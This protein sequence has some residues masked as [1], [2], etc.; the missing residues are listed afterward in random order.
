[1]N[2][3]LYLG[4]QRVVPSTINELYT[5][6]DN[7]TIGANNAI[8]VY[9]DNVTGNIGW[10]FRD[11]EKNEGYTIVNPRVGD[12]FYYNINDLTLY[13]TIVEVYNDESILVDNGENNTVRYFKQNKEITFKEIPN[14]Y[15]KRLVSAKAV[16]EAIENNS[17]IEYVA[18]DNITIGN[19]TINAYGE[20]LSLTGRT[21][22]T[23]TGA[24]A[25]TF[26]NPQVGDKAYHNTY[27][28]NLYSPIL[29]INGDTSITLSGTIYSKGVMGITHSGEVVT[30][31]DVDKTNIY[32][33]LSNIEDTWIKCIFTEDL[34]EFAVLGKNHVA[35][36]TNGIDWNTIILPE[37][38]SSW[39]DIAHV[40]TPNGY[41]IGII[42]SSSIKIYEN[43]EWINYPI[44]LPNGIGTLLKIY[45]LYGQVI[46]GDSSNLYVYNVENKLWTTVELPT[47]GSYTIYDDLTLSYTNNSNIYIMGESWITVS[48]PATS[49]I[50]GIISNSNGAVLVAQTDKCFVS[51]DGSNWTTYNLPYSDTWVSCLEV[52]GIVYLVGDTYTLYSNDFGETWTQIENVA[53]ICAVSGHIDHSVETIYLNQ[54]QPVQFNS[55]PSEYSE[56]LMSAKSVLENIKNNSGSTYS[57]GNNITIENNTISAV[58]E[59]TDKPYATKWIDEEGNIRYS[60][61]TVNIND[62]LYTDLNGTENGTITNIISSTEIEAVGTFNSNELYTTTSTGV[63]KSA[64]GLT[65]SDHYINSKTEYFTPSSTTITNARDGML[66]LTPRYFASTGRYVIGGD[67][68]TS[69]TDGINWNYQQFANEIYDIAY[70][71]GKYF[72]IDYRSWDNTSEVQ[73]YENIDSNRF[74]PILREESSNW[75]SI[76]I[77]NNIGVIVAHTGD[78]YKTTNGND[79]INVTPSSTSNWSNVR[80]FTNGST[81]TFVVIANNS[82]TV[83]YSTDGENWTSSNMTSVSDWKHLDYLNNILYAYG[84]N[85]FAYSSDGI[86]WT[87]CTIPNTFA[88]NYI[89]QSINYYNGTFLAVINGEIIT[90]SNGTTWTN[91]VAPGQDISYGVCLGVDKFVL[92]GINHAEGVNVVYQSSDAINWIEVSYNRNVN[93]VTNM[94]MNIWDSDTGTNKLQKIPCTVFNNSNVCLTEI[95]YGR[96]NGISDNI[97]DIKTTDAYNV[98]AILTE[99]EVLL[100]HPDGYTISSLDNDTS[101]VNY[102]YLETNADG[103]IILAVSGNSGAFAYSN[104]GTS[105]ST[106][107]LPTSDVWKSLTWC[108]DRF[109]LGGSS[110]YYY[111]Q[112]CIHWTRSSTPYI[113]MIYVNGMYIG[114]RANG[115]CGY[116]TDFNKWHIVS[117]PITLDPVFT[118][119]I[120]D[121]IIATSTG[122]DYMYISKSNIANIIHDV[123]FSN[124]TMKT[125]TTFGTNA[126]VNVN[127]SIYGVAKGTDILYINTSG[128]SWSEASTLPSS[129]DW[130]GIAYGNNILVVGSSSEAKLAYSSNNGTSWTAVTTPNNL[131]GIKAMTYGYDKFI[132][133][134]YNS[135]QFIYSLDGESWIAN[136]LPASGEWSNIVYGY[137]HKDNEH[138]YVY[139]IYNPNSSTIVL[140]NI[141][142]TSNDI[143][144]SLDFYIDQ[145]FANPLSIA[146]GATSEYPNGVFVGAFSNNNTLEIGF[147][148]DGMIWNTTMQMSDVANPDNTKVVFRPGEHT[149][150]IF[151]DGNVYTTINGIDLELDNG[152]GESF[153]W[154][155][156]CATSEAVVAVPASATTNFKV[157]GKAARN[158]WESTSGIGSNANR[159]M[160]TTIASTS[161]TTKILT[162]ENKTSVFNFVPVSYKDVILSG[163]A[164]FTAINDVKADI[165][166]IRQMLMGAEAKLDEILS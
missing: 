91:A 163:F 124:M 84:T 165:N 10:I 37:T 50:M 140:S 123:W 144:G 79:W 24:Y 42:D 75:K 81:T 135:D 19:N 2:G 150:Y 52:D 36:S 125:T 63:I 164:T 157:K 57:A 23:E 137:I 12:N 73:V 47:S 8:S 6:G 76:D 71:F 34:K 31:I 72:V 158:Y 115:R 120:G 55:V 141:S 48:T 156:T 40:M 70:G 53:A 89:I 20:D 61:T 65:W 98:N 67:M 87:D 145:L 30:I 43:N 51:A 132:A 60:T 92:Y 97:L 122:D 1:M 118:G 32:T 142:S 80:A 21:Y 109:V 83:I 66:S 113:K 56:K 102:K 112:D 166:D 107:T 93:F 130:E 149:F 90:S 27:D 18:G 139:I 45:N 16:I 9:G 29:A 46:V 69:S 155:A 96:F 15:S 152:N 116:S 17:G 68:R 95:S 117:T 100:Y 62:P 26:E 41:R 101:T 131:I 22:K 59:N 106:N 146:F 161:E 33:G 5:K 86:T 54:N 129:S 138:R 103:S 127:N 78:I 126:L 159:T 104:D 147:S 160:I 74:N 153:T 58:G 38:S 105:W 154:G 82:D 148:E 162:L 77:A 14:D 11:L 133:P 39:V 7:V 108:N 99:N 49:N 3:T 13:G 88:E 151:N 44:E 114:F 119:S 28:M 94:Y 128:T 143:G 110:R 4:S 111:T 136:T 121:K 134:I 85:C 64:D 35:W 25:Y